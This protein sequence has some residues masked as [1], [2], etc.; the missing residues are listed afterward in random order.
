[1]AAADQIVQIALAYN[2]QNITEIQPNDGWTNKQYQADMASV[3]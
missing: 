1:M 2:A 3:G